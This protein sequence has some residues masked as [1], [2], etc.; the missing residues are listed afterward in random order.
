MRDKY[1]LYN[2]IISSM[3]RLARTTNKLNIRNAEKI[4]IIKVF[5]ELNGPYQYHGACW[6][7]SAIFA[8]FLSDIGF[9]TLTPELFREDALDRVK[10][11]EAIF[12]IKYCHSSG[13]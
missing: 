2:H 12:I 9:G 1:F 6:V 4:G 8:M 13:Y 7:H 10:S 5:S 3:E 11:D